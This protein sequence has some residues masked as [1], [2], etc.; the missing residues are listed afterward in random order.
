MTAPTVI[1]LAEDNSADVFLIREALSQRGSAYEL[2]V[3]EDGARVTNILE[4]LGHDLPLPRIVLMDLNLPKVD[5]SD[6]LQKIRSHPATAK[7]PVIV[8]TSSRSPRDRALAEQY[9]AHY[10]HKPFELAEFLNLGEVV[11]QLV[12][13]PA[14]A[15]ENSQ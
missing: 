4:R 13:Q 8:I 10:F 14:T 2:I 3:A 7:L 1:F 9:N 6:L 11:W 12:D 5:G 15:V